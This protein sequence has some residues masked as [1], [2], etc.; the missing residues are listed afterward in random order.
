MGGVGDVGQMG[1]DGEVKKEKGR[2]K[3]RNEGK[4]GKRK[5]KMI[6]RGGC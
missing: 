4:D 1:G 3:G 5:G 6:R 2:A